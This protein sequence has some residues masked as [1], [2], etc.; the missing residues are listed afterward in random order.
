MR[1]ATMETGSLAT[2]LIKWKGTGQEEVNR[3]LKDF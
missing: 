2:M 1:R 3:Q